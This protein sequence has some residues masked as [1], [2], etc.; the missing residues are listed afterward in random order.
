MRAASG[1]KLPVAGRQRATAKL[2]PLAFGH[3]P[4]DAW[5]DGGLKRAQL[6]EIFAE[7]ADDSGSAA[8]F[9]TMLSLIA[10]DGDQPVLWLRTTD[11]ARRGGHIHAAGLAEL[12]G[13]PASLLLAVVP[14]ALALLRASV[15]ALRCGGLA[16]VIGECWGNPRQFDLVASRRLTLAAERTGVP[17]LMLRLNAKPSPS[18]ADTRWSVRSAPSRALEAKAPGYPTLDLTLLRRRGGPADR[19]WRVEW[20]REQRRFRKPPLSGAVLPVPVGGALADRERR[21]GSG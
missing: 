17:A 14:D 9:A 5:L 2:P 13:N 16:A 21:V 3:A 6:H 10:Q 20:Q 1:V 15:D 12:G 8:A 19:S 11:A 18:T 4:L 7:S